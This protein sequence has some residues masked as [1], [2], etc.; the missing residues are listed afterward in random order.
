MSKKYNKYKIIAHYN[1]KP[2]SNE[3][4]EKAFREA[5]SKRGKEIRLM[6]TNYILVARDK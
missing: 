6:E 4:E 3:S 1:K 5:F 2:W